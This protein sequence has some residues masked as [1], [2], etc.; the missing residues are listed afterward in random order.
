MATTIDKAAAMKA[1]KPADFAKV[2]GHTDGG[3]RVRARLRS[4]GVHVSKGDAF[5]AKAKQLLWDIFV[6]GKQ[7][8]AKAKE[9][10]G[11]NSKARRTK[12]RKEQA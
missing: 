8:A 9:A 12:A 3:K 7:A 6:E 10:S 4:N 5:D 11:G 2:I 1:T